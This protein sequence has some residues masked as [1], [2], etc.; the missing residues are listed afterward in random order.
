MSVAASRVRFALAS[1][2]APCYVRH[3]RGLAVGI[4][5]R[6]EYVHLPTDA[7]D[8]DASWAVGRLHSIG[9]ASPLRVLVNRER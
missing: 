5:I 3:R 7:A 6:T 1:L 4:S 8:A 2:M 9:Q